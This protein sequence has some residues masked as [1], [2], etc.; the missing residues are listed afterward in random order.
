MEILFKGRIDDQVKL[1]GYRIELGEIDY[2]ISGLSDIKNVITIV[3]EDQIG[4][5]RL[6]SYIILNNTRD[7]NYINELKEKWREALR[8]KLPD[9]MIPS[10][11]MV[12]EELPLT[13]NGK[14]D[15]KKLPIPEAE[16]QQYVEPRTEEEV[17]LAEIWSD[18]FAKEQIGVNDNF[19]ELGG[20]SLL[21]VRVI[22]ILEKRTGIDLPMTLIFRHPVLRDLAV[23]YAAIKEVE[24]NSDDQKEDQDKLYLEAA[25]RSVLSFVAT[26]P[27]QEIWQE[28]IIGGTNANISY[29]V[30]HTEYQEGELDIEVLKQSIRY[31]MNRHELLCA[32]FSKDG[33]MIHLHPEAHHFIL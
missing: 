18:V 4:D 25:E 6:V 14:V 28:C 16:Q 10:V 13:A 5:Q 23:E 22:R 2:H 1:R 27:Q 33:I 30:T 15:R 31:L 9:Y 20:H 3:R 12:L 8:N 24:S 19:F 17:M 29:N 26:E 32:T 7:K 21:A 11:F